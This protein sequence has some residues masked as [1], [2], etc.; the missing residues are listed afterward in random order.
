MNIKI[1]EMGCINCDK[2]YERVQEAISEL[3]LNIVIE[4]EEDI[5]KIM[6]YGVI[7]IPALIIDEQ[8]IIQGKVPKKE[9]IKKILKQKY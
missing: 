8:V 3:G 2:L 9:E 7:K 1:L 5:S 6:E 4:K